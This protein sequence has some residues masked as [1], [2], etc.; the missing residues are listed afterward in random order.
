MGS[1]A[2]C[3]PVKEPVAGRALTHANQR[4]PRHR[5]AKPSPGLPMQSDD[6][7]IVGP[8]LEVVAAVIPN[9][10]MP[11]PLLP[12]GDVPV[13]ARIRQRMILDLDGETVGITGTGDAFRERPAGQDTAM[14]HAQVVV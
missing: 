8:F 14:L 12:G 3:H 11:G 10:D 13:E 4:K 1:S 6:D 7:L 2:G 9:I 5:T